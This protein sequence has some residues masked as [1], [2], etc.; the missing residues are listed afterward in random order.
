MPPSHK[1]PS[2]RPGTPVG[3][4]RVRIALNFREP[5]PIYN[6][7]TAVSPVPLLRIDRNSASRL[8]NVLDRIDMP[9]LAAAQDRQD[10]LAAQ[11]MVMDMLLGTDEGED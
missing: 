7:D 8:N 11:Q 10:A 3:S 2:R 9:T 1:F 6:A 5:I 4:Y